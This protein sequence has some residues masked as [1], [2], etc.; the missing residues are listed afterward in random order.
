MKRYALNEYFLRIAKEVASRSTCVDKQ[1]GCVIV[2]A[3]NHIVSCGYNGS[4]AGYE[5]CSDRGECAKQN[6][7]ICVAIHAE[8]NAVSHMHNDHLLVFPLKAYCTLEPC[9]DCAKVLRQAGVTEVYFL[10]RTNAAKSGAHKFIGEWVQVVLTGS[11]QSAIGEA[12]DRIRIYHRLLGYPNSLTPEERKRQGAEIMLGMFQEV[13]EL[14]QS[15]DW[16]PWKAYGGTPSAN[17]DNLLE[18]AGDILFFIDSLL[19]NFGLTW[20]QLADRMVAK[21]DE[22]VARIDS[23]YHD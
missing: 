1:V 5:H 21:V 13:A 11:A 7:R 8:A 17:Q 4:P 3:N 18:E 2:D 9:E 6:G 14:T 10:A 12:V 22:C 16:K 19:M 20:G 15:F 23:G